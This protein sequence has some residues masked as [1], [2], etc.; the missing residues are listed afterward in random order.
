MPVSF[1]L[2]GK[3]ALVVG[4]AGPSIGGT[5]SRRLAE[6]GCA[7][8]V[9]DIDADRARATATD[10]AG[11]GVPTV[12]IAVDVRRTA[13]IDRMMAEATGELGGLDV[14]VTIIGGIIEFGVPIQRTHEYTDEQWQRSVDLNL[15]YVFRIVRASVQQMVEQ[16]TGG[17]IVSVGSMAGGTNAS[18]MIA[19]YGASKA[20]LRHLAGTVAAEY[21]RYGIRMNVVAP[22]SIATDAMPR[23]ADRVAAIERAVPA[24][25]VGTPTDI[26]NVVLFLASPLASYVTGQELTVDGG[27]GR[28]NVLLS[29]YL[30]ADD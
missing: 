5:T 13:E 12:G 19:A 18:P 17:S 7:I 2:A 3:R 29:T 10:L 1:E 27:L 23:D 8:A 24:A 28:Q 16:G 6:A 9:A 20:A 4:G 14:V 21:G 15:D 11:L 26:A 22:G 25:R 30:P